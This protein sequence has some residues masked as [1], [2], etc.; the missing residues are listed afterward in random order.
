MCARSAAP[1]W[2]WACAGLPGKPSA[3]DEAAARGLNLMTVIEEHPAYLLACQQGRGIFDLPRQEVPERC[4][5][6]WEPVFQWIDL[7]AR[8]QQLHRQ[9]RATGQLGQV[10]QGTPA[11]A[12]PAGAQV[13]LSKAAGPSL[14]AASAPPGGLAPPRAAPALAPALPTGQA[15]AVATTAP[16]N[17]QPA[18]RA[19]ATPQPAPHQ[20]QSDQHQQDETRAWWHKLGWPRRT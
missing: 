17:A 9:T 3:R 19:V 13:P 18:H 12:N 20:P 10:V 16:A 15:T 14:L 8:R 7:Q 1:S 2:Q 11:G 5:L 4:L 6:Q